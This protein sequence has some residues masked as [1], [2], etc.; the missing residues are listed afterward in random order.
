MVHSF[1]ST[2]LCSVPASS[3]PNTYSN[4]EAKS[5]W[6]EN[7]RVGRVQNKTNNHKTKTTTQ[8]KQPN[9]KA[10]YK[11]KQT[12]KPQ[13]QT[14]NKPKNLQP[15]TKPHHPHLKPTHIPSLQ[16]WEF[17]LWVLLA[18]LPRDTA[19]FQVLQIQEI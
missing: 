19:P 18:A 15:Q 12:T 11:T 13:P 5:K 17:F 2:F 14:P 6:E 8:T 16:L 4:P 10:P 7:G 1:I 3:D 9:K